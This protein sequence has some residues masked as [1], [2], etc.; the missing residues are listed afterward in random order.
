MVRKISCLRP[1]G[2]EARKRASTTARGRGKRQTCFRSEDELTLSCPGG[3]R[4]EGDWRCQQQQGL[5]KI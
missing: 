4:G 5:T 1:G 2:P 3:R